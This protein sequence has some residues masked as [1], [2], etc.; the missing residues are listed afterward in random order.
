MLLNK[1]IEEINISDISRMLRQDILIA[2]SKSIEILNINPLAG[3]MYDG[4]LLELLYS[5]DL[6]KYKEYVNKIKDILIK[7]KNNID[8]FEWICTDD[9]KEYLE[10]LEKYLKKIS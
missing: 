4:Q 7:I 2:V 3:E 9:S 1:T 8:S 10:I 6:N 5:V